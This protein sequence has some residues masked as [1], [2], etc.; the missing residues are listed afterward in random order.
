[1]TKHS[2][3]QRK[4][5]LLLWDQPGIPANLLRRSESFFANGGQHVAEADARR[6]RVA[7]INY[8]LQVGPVPAIHCN[9]QT[10][11]SLHHFLLQLAASKAPN[12][13]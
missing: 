9:A 8:G 6:H 2:V 10:R 1:M 11:L 7:V 5:A 3:L 13:K 4:L 12:A